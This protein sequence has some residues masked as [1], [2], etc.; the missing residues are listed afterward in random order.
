VEPAALIEQLT[1]PLRTPGKAAASGDVGAPSEPGLYAWWV[2]PGELPGVQGPSHPTEAFELLYIGI[3]PSRATS[4]AT[5]RS[6]VVGQHLGGNI[7]GSTFRKSLTALL[8]QEKGWHPCWK[9]DR[10]MLPPNEEPLLSEW[11]QLCLR[12]R[13][14][15]RLEPWQV[16][17]TVIE[18]MKPPL[19]L[20]AN[21]LHPFHATLSAARAALTAAAK[22][23]D[24]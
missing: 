24:C 12:V 6:R 11:Q 15:P 10:A 21:K 7:G 9:S 5:I 3:A 17:A 22:L 18:S 19:N 1:T 13:W 20:A 8:W 23:R 14:A 16:E 2:A 4:A